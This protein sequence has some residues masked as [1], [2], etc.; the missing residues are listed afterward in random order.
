MVDG[1]AITHGISEPELSLAL[2]PKLILVFFEANDW[3]YSLAYCRMW[4]VH[5]H[6]EILEAGGLVL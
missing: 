3:K 2:V 6:S 1:G 4:Q 5:R